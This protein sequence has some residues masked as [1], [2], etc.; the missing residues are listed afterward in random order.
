MTVTDKGIKILEVC[1]KVNVTINFVLSKSE[2]YNFISVVW[3][4]LS[5]ILQKSKNNKPKEILFQN[6]VFASSNICVKHVCKFDNI[7]FISVRFR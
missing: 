4:S 6:S 2:Y 1:L 3:F 7:N 5:V